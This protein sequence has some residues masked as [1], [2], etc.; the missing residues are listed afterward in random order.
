M[1]FDY[2]SRDFTTI[3]NDLLARASRVFPEWT[4]RDSSDFGMLMVDLWAYSA[5]VLHYYIDRAANEAF[6]ST[7]TQRESLLALA[8]LFDYTPGTRSRASATVTL[9]N[10]SAED[11]VV[12]QYTSFLIDYDGVKRF[13]YTANSYTISANSTGTVVAYQGS[14]VFPAETLTSSSSGLIAQRYTLRNSGV[15]QSTVEIDVKEN[16]VDPVRYRRVNRL[17]LSGAN[18]RVYSLTQTAD[19]F[20]QV[21]FGNG[22]NGF[23]P[24]INSVITAV[25]GSSDGA[26]GNVP[27]N[28]VAGFVAVPSPYLSVVSSTAFTGGSDDETIVSL[29]ANIPSAISAQDRAVTLND[30]NNLALQVSGITKAFSAYTAAPSASANASVTVYAHPDRSTDYLTTTDTSQTVPLSLR[31]SVENYIQPRTLLGVEVV[32]QTTIDWTSVYVTAT[33][34]I[35]ER[36]IASWVMEDVTAA[37]NSLFEF[38]NVSF[39]Q[40]LTL[41]EAYRKILDVEGVDYAVISVFD[42]SSG[43]SAQNTISIAANRLPKKG[44]FNL[45]AV[46]GSTVS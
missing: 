31:E 33:V 34:H 46:G 26:A 35:N 18:E 23:V 20:T 19:G 9:R 8:A 3:R 42:T 27:I 21:T 44:A 5:D 29:K 30:F 25:Y 32:A 2:A 17:G 10:T 38:E 13:A 45:S 40:V 11:I 24:P 4:D 1:A 28:S 7:A 12:P 36:Y 41:G 15:V 37:L 43:G 39:G 22:V 6:L 14:I 16:G